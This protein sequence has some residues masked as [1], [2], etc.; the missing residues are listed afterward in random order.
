MSKTHYASVDRANESDNQDWW[1][2]T[3]CGLEYTE[4]P[5]SDDITHVSCKKCIKSYPKYKEVMKRDM[6]NCSY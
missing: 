4:S 6:A 1:S 3:L 2:N 5:L